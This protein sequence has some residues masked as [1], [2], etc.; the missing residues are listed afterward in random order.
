M[1]QGHYPSGMA[2]AAFDILA[3]TRQLR[4]GGFDSD[5]AEAIAEAVRTG[6][7]GGVATKADIAELKAEFAELKADFAE[8]RT[9]LRWVKAIGAGI[10]GILVVAFGF[11]F[12]MLT[13]MNAALAALA[14]GG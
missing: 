4:A 13:E 2:D 11:V 10:V 14:S 6:V 9:D 5:Q 7:T 3:M 1:G 12:S 8:L